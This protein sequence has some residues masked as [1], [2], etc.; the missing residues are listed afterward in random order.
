M[1]LL[2]RL[3]CECSW[4]HSWFLGHHRW[5]RTRLDS[6][7]TETSSKIS[8]AVI[9]MATWAKEINCIRVLELGAA[10]TTENREDNVSVCSAFIAVKMNIQMNKQLNKECFQLDHAVF[11]T[12]CY[13]TPLYVSVCVFQK[14]PNYM[15]FIDFTLFQMKKIILWTYV[16]SSTSFFVP[17]LVIRLFIRARYKLMVFCRFVIYW[18]C[19]VLRKKAKIFQRST[20][21][22]E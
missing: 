8:Q 7:C 21:E 5:A 6:G 14:R 20:G 10:P 17:L 11:M 18:C 15:W 16:S 13:N 19:T 2:C 3:C 1:S 4:K 12:I 9:V 22:Q